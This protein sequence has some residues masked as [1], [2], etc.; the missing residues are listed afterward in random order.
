M[1]TELKR[2]ECVTCGNV[3]SNVDG[4]YVCE[5]CGNVYEEVEKI[6]E[7]EVI[8]LNHATTLRKRWL[9]DDAW[10]EYDLILKKY[11]ENE[12][13]SWGALICEYGI[14]YE[15]DYDGSRKINCHRLSEKPIFE[16]ANYAKLNEEHKAEAEKIEALRLSILEKSKKIQPYDVFICYK[17][18]DERFGRPT[19]EAAWARDLYEL[20]TH[21]MGLRVFYAEKALVTANTEWEPHIYAALNSAKLMFV[22]TSSLENVNAVWVKN[23]WKRFHRY[24]KE[25]QDK[26]IRVVFDNMEAYNLPKE[27][28]DTQAINHNAMDWGQS[29]EA[30][31][32]FLC[33]KPA[34]K[35]AMELQMEE[36]RK[37][38]EAMQAQLA[39]LAASQTTQAAPTQTKPVENKIPQ[40]APVVKKDT[41][42]DDFQIINGVL[43]KYLG[44]K[45]GAA[46][47][48]PNRV[49][50][51]GVRAFEGSYVKS[52]TIP[53]GVTEIADSAFS[54]CRYLEKVLIPNSV[55][56][57]GNS[58][59]S[60]CSALKDIVIPDSIDTMGQ[61]FLNCENVKIYYNGTS[62]PRKYGAYWNNGCSVLIKDESGRWKTTD[63]AD[64]HK[65]KGWK[66]WSTGAKIAW[67][68]L[69]IYT[70]G[71]P[72]IGLWLYNKYVRK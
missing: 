38:N 8:A 7:E 5:A 65:K 69:N 18:T 63:Y 48:I 23:E 19:R 34:E 41:T 45:E 58:V 43:I 39:A 30:A 68:I 52:V 56:T 14:I 55:V 50:K 47:T 11:P 37:Q 36:M 12:A 28:Q 66:S 53:F 1:E 46:V 25:G 54:N 31:A 70:Y 13:A 67:V 2:F 9:F 15:T 17:Q 57:M 71:V 21:K 27:L 44:L 61:P 62:I 60:G 24:I 16:N 51:I 26:V 20:L 4:R 22:L 35:S 6:S 59:F 64:T 72:A 29:V 49:N 33:N 32:E 42:G 3:L 10:E 40:A